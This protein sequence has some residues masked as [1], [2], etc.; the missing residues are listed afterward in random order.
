VLRELINSRSVIAAMT[1]KQP[2]SSR[3]VLVSVLALALF[4]AILLAPSRAPAAVPVPELSWHACQ[5]GFQ[6]ATARVPLD[7]SHPQ[8]RTIHL[9]VI[10]Q[11]ATDPAHRIGTLFL[12]PGGPGGSG[13]AALPDFV[14]LFPAAVRARFDIASWDPRGVGASTPVE[15]FAS[16]R[17]ANRFL[18][19]MVV[20]NSF[21][22]ANAEMAGWIRR[23][24]AA[25]VC[26]DMSRPP[27]RPGTWT[28][29]ATPWAIEG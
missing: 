20:G 3:I 18:D 7:Y 19:G 14:S 16:V 8:G 27:T 10:R 11:R 9:A 13:V 2:R 12:N 5:K 22:V 29:C 15:C 24:G 4:L 26:C 6:C 1:S 28:C 25:A 23:Y 21:P 17:D